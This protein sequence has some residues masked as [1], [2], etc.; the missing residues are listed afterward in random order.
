[1][2]NLSYPPAAPS[3]PKG[4]KLRRGLMLLVAFL[5]GLAAAV[6]AIGMIEF[7]EDRPPAGYSNGNPGSGGLRRSFPAM[8]QRADNPTTKEKS[9]LGRL[10]FF[11]PILSG[12][13]T[14]SCATCHHPDLGFSDGRFTS[15]GVG[16]QGTG[17]DRKSGKV[18]RRNAP[19]IWNAAYNFKLFW[20]GRAKDLEDQARSP[21]TAADEMNQ[22]P[23]E[24]VEE[25]KKIPEYVTSFDKAFAGSSG[26]A[27]T[28]ENVTNAVAA[29]ERTLI[30]NN[31]PF[32]RYAAGDMTALTA[33][34]RRGLTLFRSLKTRCFECHGFPT[35]ANPDFKV[36]GVPPMLGQYAQPDDLGRAEIE[37]G[38]PY[39]H[40]FKVPTLRNIALT[41][42]YMHN[43]RF[44]T[45][46][47]VVNFY[48]SGGGHGNGMDLKNIDDKVRRFP[49]TSEERNDLIA[50]LHAL[51]DESNLPEFPEKV[52]SG[53]PVVPRLK[54][55]IKPSALAARNPASFTAVP[56][57]ARR[58]PTTWRIQPG[59][60]IQSALDRSVAGDTIEIQPGAYNETLLIDMDNITIRGIV[61]NGQR[62]ILDGQNKLTDAVITSGHRFTIEGLMVKDYL[63]NGI[64]VH[65][66]TDVT[67]RDLVVENT[68]LYGVYPVEC[69]GV[70]V[71]NC[72][73]TKIKDAAI[74]VG[75]SRDIIVR[76]NECYENVAGIEIENSVNALVE[77]NYL[78]DNTGGILV[79]LL[80]NN[81]S[82]VGSD[83]KIRNNRI[84][85]NNHANFGDPNAIVGKL[86]PGTGMLIMAADRTEVTAN[87]IRANDSFGLAVVGL[88]VAFPKGRTFDVGSIPESNRIFGNTFADNGRNPAGLIKDIGAKN[89][90]IFW[91]GSG[92]NNS[93]EQSGVKSFPAILPSDN[94]PNPLRR[95]FTRGFTLIRDKWL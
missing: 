56:A 10:L 60:S 76:N 7:P 41:A 45:L 29:F 53:L 31:S 3:A 30:S 49:I 1:M 75:Q 2:N 20:D 44:L 8:N 79:F 52:P 59:E 61:E 73:L 22:K 21:I 93:F 42:P 81:P 12:D 51:T 62:A 63:N 40:A 38:E 88:A 69:K 58:D 72:K 35:F 66:A 64:T 83:H 78:H 13:N 55:G 68:G 43:G 70:L 67:F 84:I 85:N 89:C 33:E 15:M 39:N 24:L 71:E 14:L 94:W 77:N 19:T 54:Q 32:D 82:K 28:F 57:P 18:L 46:E 4:R 34:Q 36:I 80:P 5:G 27:V 37:G 50:F 25:L 11:D 95:A 86:I 92:W 6:L 23:E 74:Y 91:D 90:D 17:L 26:S 87:E 65:G 9:E 16:G 47:D 48:A